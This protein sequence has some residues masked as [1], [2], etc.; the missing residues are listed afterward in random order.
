M[1]KKLVSIIIYIPIIS[2]GLVIAHYM[3][4]V[5]SESMEPVLFK[6][7][8]VIID[9]NPS[10]IETG[11]IIIYYARWFQNRHVIHRVIAKEESTNGDIIYILKGDNNEDQDPDP[12]SPKDVIA[13]VVTINNQPLIIP[14]IGYITLWF[15]GNT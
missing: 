3:N 6:G 2:L 15:Q 1:K 10:S 14:K 12:V 8:V 5:A 11:D 4:V 7:D 9:Y 13:K